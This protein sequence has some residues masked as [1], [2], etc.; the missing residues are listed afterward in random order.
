M[1]NAEKY[2][3]DKVSIEEIAKEFESFCEALKEHHILLTFKQEMKEFL[4]C[5]NKVIL[6]ENEKIILMNIKEAK[7]IGRAFSSGLGELYIVTKTGERIVVYFNKLFGH[8]FQSIKNN[9]EYEI[10]E[11]LK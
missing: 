4:N 6:S 7:K 9:E 8:L 3:K 2:L 5:E 10:E 11:L 1:T